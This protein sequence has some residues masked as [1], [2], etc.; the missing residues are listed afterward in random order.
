MR[1]P[2]LLA[3]A[4]ALP[5]LAPAAEPS[6]DARGHEWWRHAVFYEIYPR[7]FADADGNGTGDLAG[8]AAKLDYLKSLGVDAIWIT[9][10]YPSPQVD[11]GYDVSDYRAIAPEYGTLADFDRLIDGAT[12][13]GIRIVMDLVMNH[14]SDQHP[15]FVESR[16]S[17]A[18]PKRDWYVWRDGTGE[19][20]PPNNWISVFGGSAWQWDERTSQY[21][22]HFFYKEQPDLN[23]RNPAVKDAYFDVARYWMDRGVAGFRLDAIGTLFEDPA[24][25]DN[26]VDPG[27]NWLGDP[28]MRHEHNTDL[29]EVHDVVRDLRRLADSYPGD[30]VLVG[31]TGG[32]TIAEIA[33]WY[34]AKLD[35]FQLPMNFRFANVNKLSAPEF[36]QRIADADANPAGGWPVYLL[37]NHDE[38][39]QWNRY[40]DGVDN[41]AIARLLATMIL[42]L[43]GTP[44]LYYGEELGMENGDPKRVEDVKDPIGKLFWPKNKGRD[45]E[46][47]PMQWD[48]TVNAGFSRRAPWLPVPES[49]GKKNVAVEDK[50]PGSLLNLYRRLTTLRR[51]TPALL[52][53]EYRALLESDPNVLAY[54]RRDGAD[55]VVV[56]LNM[57]GAPQSVRLD[58]GPL[59]LTAKDSTTLLSTADTDK[60][61]RPLGDLSLAPFEGYVGRVK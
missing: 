47:T 31:E 29:P 39:R 5:A 38:D 49:A 52:E 8:I 9:P 15:W 33:R 27:V 4:F 40:G 45:G 50:D 16:A 6:R 3:I 35:E 48:A 57:S 41:D 24:L 46:R 43:R 44:I 7:S 30:R 14:T 10:C 42:T 26:P 58:L 36:R 11:F 18:S 23:W 60:R 37:G 56:A 19:G 25:T 28:N 2:L 22:Y 21:Y 17:R 12:K 53:G 54:L 55:A 59:G 13:H 32:Q 34:G 61:A 20:K 1:H 51:S